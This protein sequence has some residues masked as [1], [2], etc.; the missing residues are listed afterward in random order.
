M[1]LRELAPDLVQGRVVVAHLGSGCS[2]AAIRIRPWALL[3]PLYGGLDALVFTSGIGEND[4]QLRRRVCANAAWLGIQL[5]E[6]ANREGLTHLA[7]K[8]RTIGLGHPD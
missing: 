3:S 5:D 6:A 1:R 2:L 4:T 8:H 7:P